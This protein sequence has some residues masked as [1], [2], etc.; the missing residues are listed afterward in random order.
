MRSLR[1]NKSKVTWRSTFIDNV[2]ASEIEKES[3]N[4]ETALL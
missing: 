4:D 3:R 1:V 2:L